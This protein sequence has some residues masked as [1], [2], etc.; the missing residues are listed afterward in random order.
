MLSRNVDVGNH[1]QR[2]AAHEPV[3]SPPAS[4][5][6]D[7]V[8]PFLPV[9]SSGQVFVLM[10]GKPL[11]LFSFEHKF[12]PALPRPGSCRFQPAAQIAFPVSIRFFSSAP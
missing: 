1:V 2:L 5:D 7:D 4:R 11:Q 8:Q 3:M 9:Q 10:A 6:K 12:D